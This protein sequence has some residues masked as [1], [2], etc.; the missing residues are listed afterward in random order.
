MPESHTP[1]PP[2]PAPRQR[3]SL[4][5]AL[6]N[7]I[8]VSCFSAF[9]K[10][11]AF[12]VI[13]SITTVAGLAFTAVRADELVVATS[14]GRII[15]GPLQPGIY[16]YWPYFNT[17][18]RYPSIRE[19]L[20]ITEKRV[21]GGTVYT[22][23]LMEEGIGVSTKD[24][25]PVTVVLELSYQILRDRTI[26]ERFIQNWGLANADRAIEKLEKII[27]DRCRSAARSVL[28]QADLAT[29]EKNPVDCSSK[30]LV[31]ATQRIVVEGHAEFGEPL[32]DIGVSVLSLGYRLRVDPEVKKARAAQAAARETQVSRLLTI[33]S[34]HAV[35]MRELEL[36]AKLQSA[37]L[38]E[39]RAARQVFE[40]SPESA[41]QSVRLKALQKWDGRLPGVLLVGA[42]LGQ[43]VD[44]LGDRATRSPEE[45]RPQQ[46]PAEK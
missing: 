46:A 19:F 34:E 2:A 28:E 12:V 45:S 16:W 27:A 13:A 15:D 32:A 33:E 14:F 29:I 6:G 7:V 25:V 35:D 8:V 40:S 18:Q 21:E 38:E 20:L 9:G 4:L 36:R 3:R 11:M 1:S 42:D 10:F 37:Q 17:I 39:A 31:A 44:L 5:R 43:Y 41:P 24:H 30:I 23:A 26:L 22:E